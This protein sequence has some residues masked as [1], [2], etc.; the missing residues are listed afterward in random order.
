MGK[1]SSSENFFNIKVDIA[2]GPD[3]NLFGNY[4]KIIF[5]ESQLNAMLSFEKLLIVDIIGSLLSSFGYVK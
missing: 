3:E 2:S 1:H 5:T 4:F